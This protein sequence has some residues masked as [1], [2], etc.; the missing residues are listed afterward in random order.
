MIGQLLNRIT[1]A[2]D[3][4]EIPFMVSGSM[5]L[6]VYTV[7]RMTRDIDI[8]I[9]LKRDD[10]ERFCAIFKEGYYLDPLTVEEEVKRKG[11]FNAIDYETG[12]KIDFM[13]RK[14]DFYRRTEFDRRVRGEV[15]GCETWLVTLE[16][17]I[18]SKLIWIQELQSDRQMSDIDNLLENPNVDMDYVNHWCKELDLN[19]FN[20]L[21]KK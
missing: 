13:V 12:Y 10:I 11:M 9:E 6:I 17:L 7:P 8:V 19:T 21:N 16:D 18:I 2:L 4:A 15:M 20:L 3:E 14:N 1:K 5:A